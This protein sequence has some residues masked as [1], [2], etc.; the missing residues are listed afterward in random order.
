[1][2]AY[3]LSAICKMTGGVLKGH[4]G[5]DQEI[6]EIL[7]DSRRLLLA[8]GTL[9]VALKTAK[10]DGHA[11]IGDLVAKGVRN[12]MVSDLPQGWQQQVPGVAFILVADTLASLQQLAALHRKKYDLPVVAITGSN[13]KTI[14][15]EWLYQLLMDRK[16]IVRNPRSYNSQIGVPL[17]VLQIHAFHELGIFEAGISQPGEMEN[18]QQ[19][20]Q[21]DVGIFT[22]I[23]PAHDEGFA[24][25]EE[26]IEEKLQLFTNCRGLIYCLDH[27]VL[28]SQIARWHKDNPSVRLFGW[29]YLPGASMQVLS[30]H[31]EESHTLMH[32]HYEKQDFFFT[33][34]FTDQ[35]SVEN[36]LHCLAF[37]FMAGF[38]NEW[39]SERMLQLQP[40]AMRLEMKEGI[41]NCLIIN[42]SYN[43]DLNSLSI[44]LDFMNAQSR[45][46]KSTLIL[47]DILQ[48]G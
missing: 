4:V 6:R 18:L 16:N 34:P 48:S 15:K 46:T 11:F 30:V 9:F 5:S 17:S 44:A 7:T 12:F 23:G 25:T 36:A 26:K 31:K 14:I 13:G 20:I 29:S 47:S 35:A 24:T 1:M 28:A 42:D 21:P 3:H 22:N 37:L 10:N 39:V 33:I 41:N 40:V 8:E 27:Y 2:E 43:S 32:L 38:S 19:I 45:Y